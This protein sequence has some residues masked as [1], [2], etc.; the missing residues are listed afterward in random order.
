MRRVQGHFGPCC[1]FPNRIA[2]SSAS[3]RASGPLAMS[4][5]R[6]RSKPGSSLILLDFMAIFSLS[7]GK[8]L[9]AQVSPKQRP[10]E[11]PVVWDLKVEQ[12]MDDDPGAEVGGLL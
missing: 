3:E 4:F 1:R 12:L 10:K 7:E 5:S 11:L 9:S 2:R 8:V 6:G